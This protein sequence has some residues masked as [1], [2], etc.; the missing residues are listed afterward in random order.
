MMSNC[1]PASIKSGPRPPSVCSSS[2]SC[3]PELCLGYACQP[4]TCVSSICMPTTYPS[5]RCLPKTYL[6]SSC[7]PSQPASGISSSVSTCW[8]CEGSFNGS[9][10]ET[11]RVLN[12]R[13]ASY[14]EK[15]HQLEQENAS[16]ESK[17]QEACQSQVPTTCPDYQAYF[18]TID[19]L[20]QKVLCTKAENTRLVVHIDNAKLA[21]DDFRTK[22]EMELAMRQLVEADTNGLRRILD[23]LTLCK[24]DLEMQVE[25]LKEELLCFKKNHEEEVSALRCQLGDRLNI[26]VNIAPPVDLNRMLEEMRCQYETLVETNHRDVEEWFNAQME[27]LNQQVAMSSEQLQSYQSDI[28]DM[29][30]TVN[31]LEIDLQAQHSLRD[32]LESTLA[33]TEARCG[34]QLAQM[35]CV[36]SNVEAQLADIRCDLERQNHEYQVLLDAKAR[37]EGEIATYQGLLDSEDCK[38]PCPPCSTP[39]CRP[40]APS[41]S[42][43]RTVC[44]PRTICVPCVLAP[45]GRY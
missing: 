37:L 5:A 44:V 15:V 10:K 33:E 14:L 31:T 3:R 34:S 1:S 21:A 39:S 17:I 30:R 6:P 7:W 40:C 23:E 11:M 25:S 13:L 16:L 9:E 36:I 26:E 27:E 38:L 2:M 18:R 12:D 29:R 4:S 42:M 43:P 20:Q 41:P 45:T 19:E 8:Y 32:S 24:A 35:Q 28:I 22:Y